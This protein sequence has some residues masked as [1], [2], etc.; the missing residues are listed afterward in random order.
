MS[1]ST[2]PASEKQLYDVRIQATAPIQLTFRVLAETP[3]KALEMVE[4]RNPSARLVGT[5][6]PDLGK[7]K[8]I[9]GTVY[10]AGT[11]LIKFFKNYI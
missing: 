1:K 6:P 5:S 4:S 3:E 2:E 7:M 8:K 9:K 11:L 10:Q